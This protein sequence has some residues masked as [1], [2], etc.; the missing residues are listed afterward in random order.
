MGEESATANLL[1]PTL[2]NISGAVITASLVCHLLSPRLNVSVR[3]SSRCKQFR[4]D[5]MEGD[6]DDE[7]RSALE[8]ARHHGLCT[9][10]DREP[11]YDGSLPTPPNDNCDRDLWDPSDG[12]ITNAVNTL[13]RERLA[14]S[15]DV[16]LLLKSV[17]ELQ[18]DPSDDNLTT[19]RYHRLLSL[20][21]ELPILRTDNELDLLNFGSAAM[22]DLRDLN[23][24]FEPVNQENDEGF[25]WPTKYLTYPAQYEDQIKAEKLAI[26][27]DALLHL[28][29]AVTDNYTEEDYESIK[30]EGLQYKPVREVPVQMDHTKK[31]STPHE[32][33]SLHLY[34]HYHHL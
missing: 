24:P 27:R 28:R 25:E 23:I 11:I 1:T 31:C 19:D 8:Y 6:L 16:A 17:H 32:G 12:F 21:Q 4:I 30:E 2:F 3:V 13:T 7:G 14:V 34:Y 18:Q 9:P 10:Y 33:P 15:R 29:N 5:T 22:P 26:S 20:K